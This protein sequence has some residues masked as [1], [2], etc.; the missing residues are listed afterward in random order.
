MRLDLTKGMEK[1]LVGLLVAWL[2]CAGSPLFA[3]PNQVQ[4]TTEKTRGEVNKGKIGAEGSA[5]KSSEKVSYQIK[6]QDVSFG[7]FTN[8]TVDYILFVERQKLGEKKGTEV[9]ER[10]KGSSAVAALTRKEP[11][12]VTTNEVDLKK[13][14]LVGTYHFPNGG[15]IK[16]EDSV[17]GIWVRVSQGGQ[18]VGEYANPPTIANRGWDKP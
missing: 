11:Q 5:N 13:E 14:N 9:E 1:R 7:D 3:L 8:L 4:I 10:V 18:L 17:K 15:R 6:L 16:V 12:S 2:C